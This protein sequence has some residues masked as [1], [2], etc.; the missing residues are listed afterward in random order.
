MSTNTNTTKPTHRPIAALGLP[1]TIS[2]V[3]V[4]AENIV[5]RMTGNPHFP[6]PTPS[7]ASVTTHIGDLRVAEAAALARTKG[8]A[9]VRNQK[10]TVL[11]SDLQALRGYVQTVADADPGNAAAIIE[12]AG[13]TVRKT[14]T[15]HARALA[16][17]P[18]S[19]SGVATITAKVVSRRASYEW[20]YS[21]VEC[22]KLRTRFRPGNPAGGG[23]LRRPGGGSERRTRAGSCLLPRGLQTTVDDE[24]RI[25]P[26]LKTSAHDS[27]LAR[28]RLALGGHPHEAPVRHGAHARHESDLLVLVEVKHHGAVEHRNGIG[29]HAHSLP[30]RPASEAQQA[31]NEL[32]RPPLSRS[33]RS[34][35]L[36]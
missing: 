34:T 8:A 15:R 20:Q 5:T 33:W 32:R 27:I 13:L 1:R 2:L 18:G 19:V 16:A 35:S 23:G 4:Y 21:T 25:V 30:L 17:K 28:S 22:S 12:S 31:M 29:R 11:V 10:R 7:L 36:S 24:C 14:A 6:T 26:D 9:T 3:L